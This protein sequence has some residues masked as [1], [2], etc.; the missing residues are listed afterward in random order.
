MFV[1]IHTCVNC[2][3]V[4]LTTCITICFIVKQLNGPAIN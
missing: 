1:Y 4:F 2:S 3:D